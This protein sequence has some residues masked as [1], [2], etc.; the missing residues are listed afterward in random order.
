[1]NNELLLGIDIGTQ[2]VKGILADASGAVIAQHHVEH[3][4]FYP[5]PDWCE[6]DMSLNWWQ[7][8]VVVIRALIG[9]SGIS[10]NQIKAISISGLYPALGPTDGE[11][12]PIARAILYSDNRSVAEVDEVN[13]ALGEG[14]A[15]TGEEMVLSEGDIVEDED[16]GNMLEYRDGELVAYEP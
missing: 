9:S 1:M 10:P 11:G 2:G 5:Q 12:N 8:P 16:T 6:Q 14:E 7:N 13:K 15:S 4:C 3:G